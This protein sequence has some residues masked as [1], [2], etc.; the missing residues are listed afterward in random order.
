MAQATL[1]IVHYG[2]NEIR[3]FL[4]RSRTLAVLQKHVAASQCD[5]EKLSLVQQIAQELLG[6]PLQEE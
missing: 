4:E 6:T 5:P 2:E 3:N 1:N